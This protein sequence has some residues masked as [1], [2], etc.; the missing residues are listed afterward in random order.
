MLYIG[1]TSC[2][3]YADEMPLQERNPLKLPW[4]PFRYLRDYIQFENGNKRIYGD[5]VILCHGV[6]AF[7]QMQRVFK[8]RFPG[9]STAWRAWR[10]LV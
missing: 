9:W 5:E 6:P 2:P 1:Y 7:N 8:T 10:Q 4:A 3:L